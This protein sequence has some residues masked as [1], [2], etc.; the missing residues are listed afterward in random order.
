M[1]A[2]KKYKFNRIPLA[3]SIMMKNPDL[4]QYNHR[5]EEV[6]IFGE[7]CKENKCMICNDI[8]ELHQESDGPRTVHE[9]MAQSANDSCLSIIKHGESIN[10]LAM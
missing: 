4:N 7:R 2:Y 6:G 8:R 9:I 10:Y 1:L 5:F 3:I